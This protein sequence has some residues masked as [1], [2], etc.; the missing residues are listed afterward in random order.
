MKL[1]QSLAI[2]LLITQTA[3]AQK[4]KQIEADRPGNGVSGSITGI[5]QLVTEIGFER[6]AQENEWQTRLPNT[7]LRYGIGKNMELRLKTELSS[8]KDLLTNETQTGLQPLQL[9]TKI[10]LAAER[11]GFPSVAVLLA[12]DLPFTGS[13]DLRNKHWAP[14]LRL[15]FENKLSGKLNLNYNVATE[16]DGATIDPDWMYATMLGY[17]V[18]A[19]SKIGVEV[20]GN[21]RRATSPNHFAGLNYSYFLGN[22]IKLDASA[23]KSLVEK[24]G[25][26]AAAGF[27][28]LIK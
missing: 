11:N 21:L 6:E 18:S 25:W 17:S 9:G 1:I 23:S 3:L 5:N 12:S 2:C 26:F 22:N 4:Q 16:W 13:K 7:F 14:E 27:S 20:Y 10:A 15:I 8:T 24:D 28:F 19:S